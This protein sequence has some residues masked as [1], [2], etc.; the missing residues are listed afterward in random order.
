MAPWPPQFWI[1]SLS[2]YCCP[3]LVN[4]LNCHG[5]HIHPWKDSVLGIGSGG[6]WGEWKQSNVNLLGNA[7]MMH[8]SEQLYIGG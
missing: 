3:F 2:P 7:R 6:C 8:Q 5:A 4:Q 1:I